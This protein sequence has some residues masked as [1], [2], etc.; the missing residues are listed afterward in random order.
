SNLNTTGNVFQNGRVVI[1]AASGFSAQG[2]RSI[3]GLIS[4]IHLRAFSIPATGGSVIRNKFYDLNFD[5]QVSNTF[6]TD[7]YGNE[8]YSTQQ[9][10]GYNALTFYHGK[11]G[12]F[13]VT[14]RF[15]ALNI[16]QNL[17]YN[18]TNPISFVGNYSNLSI[19]T[20]TGTGQYVGKVNI[21]HNIIKATNAGVITTEYVSNAITLQQ[22]LLPPPGPPS[23]ITFT[24]DTRLS[25]TD[26][27]IK[28]AY[29]GI[30][31]QNWHNGQHPNVVTNTITLV[32]DLI[33]GS[34]RQYGINGTGCSTLSIFAN[35]VKG[36]NTTNTIVTGIYTSVNN[37]LS[38]TCNT[39]RVLYQGFEFAGAQSV[40]TSW[41]GNVMKTNAR[42]F[43]I[44]SN[45]IIGQQGNLSTP[46]DNQWIAGWPP[47]T[48]YTWTQNSFASNSPIY[49]RSAATYT[50]LSNSAFPVPNRYITNI[51]LF[52]SSGSFYA[53]TP[54]PSIPSPGGGSTLDMIAQD[55]IPFINV[56]PESQFI[57]KNHLF[58]ALKHDPSLMST[59]VV[60]QNFYNTS[61]TGCRETLCNI[62]TNLSN[63]NKAMAASQLSAFT[64][65]NNIETNYKQFF[66]IYKAYYDSTYTA[67]DSLN[68]AAL[69]N[70][71][72][73]IDGSVVYQARA[74]YNMIY[75][76]V[77]LFNDNCPVEENIVSRFGNN[78]E[79]S[80]QKNTLN[81]W[82]VEIHPNPA[83]EDLFIV[84]SNE[85][86]TIQVFITD[87]SGKIMANYLIK[88]QAFAGKIKL[89][90]N[91][92]IYFVTLVNQN[93]DRI[94]K[95]LIISN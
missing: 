33:T 49:V 14:N 79:S 53:C 2:I 66:Q 77:E 46:I 4:L 85:I 80:Q 64:P 55:S 35:Q 13:A 6:I 93:N 31:L 87:V 43:V 76:E 90:L 54:P 26:N 61:L 91:S 88:T 65:T 69:A 81:K 19:P 51:N 41:F 60:L 45:G 27:S 40:N 57:H 10:S 16:S 28:D 70:K 15:A 95:K 78:T 34:A 36:T 48:F 8:F 52:A 5:I 74:M 82:N 37:F 20:F 3:G 17:F 23:A 84:S 38:V 63:G 22:P 18:H 75:S 67:N 24:T 92:G 89:N 29:R 73:F 47:G 71:C 32:D 9:Q 11:F 12:V 86:E 25:I 68:L 83:S 21:D 44:S 1:G 72:P 58:R 7:I 39:V 94:V 42:G 62:E 50:P 59:D 30:F 56:I